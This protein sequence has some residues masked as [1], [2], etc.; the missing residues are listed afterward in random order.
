MQHI[1]TGCR[2]LGDAQNFDQKVP[3]NLTSLEQEAGVGDLL[4]PSNLY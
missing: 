4:I 3:E 2:V 1:Q